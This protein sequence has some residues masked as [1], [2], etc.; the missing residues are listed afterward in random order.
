MLQPAAFAFSA[1]YTGI[2]IDAVE[3]LK[4]NGY[5]IVFMDL[6]MPNRDGIDAAKG[7]AG[8]VRQRLYRR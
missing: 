1:V 7:A 3:M 4:Q 6:Q 2:A 5:D 8:P